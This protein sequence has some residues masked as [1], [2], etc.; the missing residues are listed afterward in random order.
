MLKIWTLFGLSLI[1]IYSNFSFCG[2]PKDISSKANKIVDECF[3]I[4]DNRIFIYSPDRKKREQ[5]ENQS[6][7]SAELFRNKLNELA[8]EMKENQIERLKALESRD[9]KAKL[10]IIAWDRKNRLS[11]SSTSARVNS[12]CLSREAFRALK[13]FCRS[14]PAT[15]CLAS[16]VQA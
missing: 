14:D 16:S 7:Q 11:S 5:L 1:T 13:A 4:I 3:N 8:K 2:E 10:T 9:L 6:F 15:L 12:C